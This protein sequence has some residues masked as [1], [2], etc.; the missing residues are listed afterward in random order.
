MTPEPTQF[1]RT[2]QRRTVLTRRGA[3]IEE[4]PVHQFDEDA[5]VLHRLDR[6]G[7]LNQPAGGRIGIGEGASGSS[8]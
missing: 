8:Q 5:A 1:N 2:R 3:R 6:T 4:W 7:N